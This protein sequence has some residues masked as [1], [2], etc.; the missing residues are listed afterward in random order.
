M[1]LREGMI[2]AAIGILVG[3]GASMAVARLLMAGTALKQ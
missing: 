1:F 2:F 3:A